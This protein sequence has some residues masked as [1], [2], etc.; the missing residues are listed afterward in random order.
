MKS[1]HLSDHLKF[2]LPSLAGI[3]LFM[4]PV[5]S[6]NDISL[7]VSCRLGHQDLLANHF[8]NRITRLSYYLLL[9]LGY[10]IP[11]PNR[12]ENI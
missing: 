8:V 6:G 4:I 12:P 11:S 7:P 5:P 1:Y 9:H 10:S 2:I 3:F